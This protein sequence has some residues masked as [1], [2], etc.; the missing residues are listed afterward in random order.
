[1]PK[2][3]L[4]RDVPEIRAM[5]DAHFADLGVDLNQ[6]HVQ[7]VEKA[8][9]HARRLKLRTAK[10]QRENF[11]EVRLPCNA[12][13]FAAKGDVWGAMKPS[14]RFR[15]H[16]PDGSRKYVRANLAEDWG[17]KLE[18]PCDQPHADPVKP[19]RVLPDL[20]R[21]VLSRKLAQAHEARTR[22]IIG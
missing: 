4:K 6:P 7:L 9:V 11:H 12:D 10:K 15:I 14:R 5:L 8:Q 20:T 19:V 2:L 3:T 22:T 17:G 1:M 18:R 16:L 13:Q 21:H